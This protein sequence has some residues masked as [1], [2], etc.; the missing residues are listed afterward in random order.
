MRLQLVSAVLLLG[1]SACSP[2]DPA[3]FAE[4]KWSI[5]ANDMSMTLPDARIAACSAV[6]AYA[7]APE[8]RA[9]ALVTRGVLRGE[10]GQ[11][12][13]AVADFGR[14]L[15]LDRNNVDALV[16]R[17]L[18]HF[19]RGAMESALRDY[20]AALALDP[21][22]DIALERR[23]VALQSLQDAQRSQLEYLNEALQ[24][25][26][27]NAEL[28]NNRCW[29]RAV[30]GKEL[31]LALMDCDAALRVEPANSAA[32]DSR[33]LIYLKLGDNQAALAD[34]EAALAVE[35]GRGHFL[36]GRGLARLRLGMVAEGQADL[37]AAEAAEPGIAAQ[38][39]SYGATPS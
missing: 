31:E 14:A 35:P 19:N 3:A 20:N 2:A 13:R 1:V 36:Y 27:L 24:Q 8:R 9:A 39:E 38:Y 33:G 16:E 10:M 18:V 25:D 30:E 32:L 22:F 6:A 5:C 29:L 15:R 26:P 4:A 34:Y 28:L 7:A 17:G 21:A 23:R 12:A 11:H 37:A